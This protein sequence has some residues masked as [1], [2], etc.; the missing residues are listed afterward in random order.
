[1]KCPRCWTER[2][3]VHESPGWK[4]ALWALLF[5]RPMKCAHC[6]CR[7]FAFRPLTWGKQLHPPVLRPSK[8]RS[9]RPSYAQ[10]QQAGTKSAGSEPES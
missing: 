9:N 5:L 7:F 1:M 8:I 6:Y 4:D 10:L 3:Y 2:A